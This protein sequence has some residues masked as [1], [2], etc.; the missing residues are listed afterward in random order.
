ME[1]NE[2]FNGTETTEFIGVSDECFNQYMGSI[3]NLL[4]IQVVGLG[5]IIGT[6]VCL[7]VVRWF[8]VR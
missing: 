3:S 6:L 2:V 5:L 7:A 4:Q 8:H 1:E